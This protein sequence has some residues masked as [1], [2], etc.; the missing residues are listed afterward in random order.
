MA[1][2]YLAAG[3]I[4]WGFVYFLQAFTGKSSCIENRKSALELLDA[5]YARGEISQNEYIMMK[6]DLI[7]G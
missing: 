1:R 2:T 4:L 7:S 6:E 5:R 3:L